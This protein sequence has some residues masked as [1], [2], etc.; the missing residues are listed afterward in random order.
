MPEVAQVAG[1]D[2]AGRGVVTSTPVIESLDGCATLVDEPVLRWLRLG[3]LGQDVG[4]APV[5][6]LT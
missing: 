2:R 5:G 6:L 3:V 1:E 4:D